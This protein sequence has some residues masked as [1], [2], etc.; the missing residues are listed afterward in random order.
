MTHASLFSGIGGF[1]IN[2]HVDR[3]SSDIKLNYPFPSQPLCDEQ[4]AS[5]VESSCEV[6]GNIYDNPELIK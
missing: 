2:V 1:A 6:I 4:T 5:Y 3:F